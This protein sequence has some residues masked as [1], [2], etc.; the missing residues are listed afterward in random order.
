LG[1]RNSAFFIFFRFPTS[2]YIQAVIAFAFFFPTFNSSQKE[3]TLPSACPYFASICLLLFESAYSV[4]DE[5]HCSPHHQRYDD[6][7]VDTP[8]PVTVPTTTTAEYIE[9]TTFCS[10]SH[11]TL[12]SKLLLILGLQP[13][14]DG[15]FSETSDMWPGQAMT[16]KV[17]EVLHHEKS[18]YQ[19]VLVFEST[20][21]GTVLVLDNVIQ[22]TE[23]DEF[24]YVNSGQQSSAQK[25]SMLIFG[26]TTATRR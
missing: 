6:I 26:Q 14:L 8:P 18:K 24:S 7:G 4:H 15:W 1:R 11:K 16:L 20:D 2:L 23:R 10:S 13:V 9:S 25:R 12:I 5:R 3:T 22:C 19:D 17:K 21:H